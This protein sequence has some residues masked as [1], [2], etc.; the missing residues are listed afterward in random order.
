[1]SKEGAGLT[2]DRRVQGPERQLWAGQSVDP[3][4]GS[5]LW[6]QEAVAVGKS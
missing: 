4:P 6:L 2:Q 5:W 1:M 3:D